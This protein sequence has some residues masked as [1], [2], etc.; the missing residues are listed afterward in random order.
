MAR[1][2]TLERGDGYGFHLA[3]ENGNQFIRKIDKKSPAEHA[4]ILD[5]DRLIGVNTTC[6]I[7]LSHKEVVGLIR[8][9]NEAVSLVLVT[10][11]SE[12]GDLC[13]NDLMR[14]LWPREV[15][16]TRKQNGFGFVL[17]SERVRKTTKYFMTKITPGGAADEVGV[18]N[19]DRLIKVG[20]NGDTLGWP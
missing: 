20:I 1:E 7:G 11:T 15:T 13:D 8:Q 9:S 14:L 4:G 12:I 18:A 2:V 17:H 16:L 3:S 19:D 5:G 10:A 6:I